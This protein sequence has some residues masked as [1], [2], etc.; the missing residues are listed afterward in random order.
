MPRSLGSRNAWERSVLNEQ[1]DIAMAGSAVPA[2]HRTLLNALIQFASGDGTE[3]RLTK[4][5]VPQGTTPAAVTS[6]IWTKAGKLDTMTDPGVGSTG[7]VYNYDYDTLN[8]L[9]KLTFP[10][11]GGGVVR[12][13][14]RTYDAAGNLKTFTNRSSQ[15][16]TFT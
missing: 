11:D 4:I 10:A 9:T 5:T 16:Q 6:Y 1:R 7:R 13:D 14:A 8:R 15:V 12:A 3:N 2:I